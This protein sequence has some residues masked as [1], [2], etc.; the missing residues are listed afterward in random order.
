MAR[1]QSPA[2]A[3]SKSPAKR[4]AV[5]KKSPAK[6]RKPARPAPAP[7]A[8]AAPAVPRAQQFT[9]AH[10][11]HEAVE[12]IGGIGTVLEGLMISPVY[13]KH[14][15]RSILIGPL[16]SREG[17]DPARRLG[18]HGNVLYSSVDSIDRTGLGD[19]LRPIEWAFNVKIVYGTRKFEQPAQGRSGEAEVLLIDVYSFNGDRLNVFKHRLWETFG[20]DSWR[21][22][23]S[24]DYEEYVR[25]AEPAYY[26]LRALLREEDLPCTVF[27]HEFMGM[28][29]ALKAILD[30]NDHFRTIYHAHE[31]PTAR[32]LVEDHP[33]HDTMFYN[34][35]DAAQKQG[36][37]LDDVFGDHDHA[38]RHAFVRRAALCDGIIAVGDRTRDE[39]KFLHPQF[40]AKPV[41][42]VYNGLPVVKLDLA[43]RLRCR[44]LL[45]TAAQNLVGFKPDVLMTHVTRPVIS[46]ALWRD[47]RVCHELDSRLGAAGRKGV[48]FILTSAGGVRRSADVANMHKQYG[49][50][51]HHRHG[52]PDLVGPEEGINGDIEAFNKGHEHV[53][54]VLVN[55]FGWSQRRVG[56]AVPAEMDIADLRCGTDVEFGMAVYEPFGISP[57]EPLC[58]GALCVIST[59]CGCQG[60][61]QHVTNNQGAAN[62]ICPDYAPPL[63]ETLEDKKALGVN[64]R[65]EIENVVAAQVADEILARLPRTE[66]QHQKLL[67]AG[68]ELVGMMGWDQ[69]IL[70]GLLPLLRRIN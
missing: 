14:V 6:T 51:R 28:P 4:P 35:L 9:L 53:Q 24:W 42:I 56:P 55:Q 57:L 33:G 10:V 46:K 70:D 65:T 25:L 43:R 54:V 66:R 61:V 1:K 41:D 11:T 19:K 17:V 49:W 13:Q 52:F 32:R 63:G 48:L 50:P 20:L 31:C 12:Q 23:S 16:W 2:S 18:E 15:R 40:D 60:F 39:I 7:K 47:L 27:S 3:K 29:T 62:V 45:A 8:Q 34:V 64:E 38:L 44:D 22:E 59:A 58:S 21:Y 5:S 68:Q 69:V 30:G 26:A 36:L 67:E 37:Y